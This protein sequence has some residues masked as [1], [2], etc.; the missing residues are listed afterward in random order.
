MHLLF[1]QKCLSLTRKL[2][3]HVIPAYF[4]IAK[5]LNI[6][7]YIYISIYVYI[8]LYTLYIYTLYIYIYIYYIKKL[9]RI[10]RSD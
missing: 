4:Q 10:K 2:K 9:F 6:Y 3:M 5:F 8:Y 7:I 1:S